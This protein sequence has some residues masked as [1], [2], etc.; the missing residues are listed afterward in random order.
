ML[1]PTADKGIPAQTGAEER[2]SERE[3]EESSSVEQFPALKQRGKEKKRAPTKDRNKLE[4]LAM[5]KEMKEEMKESDEK[6]KE[7]IRWRDKNMEDHINER[8]AT[9]AAYIKYRDEEW[10]K[11]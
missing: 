5:L 2:G 6:I 3:N 4:L 1:S 7:E 8:E 9:L 10:G 11:S